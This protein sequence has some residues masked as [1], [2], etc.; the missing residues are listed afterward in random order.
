MFTS[1]PNL[2]WENKKRFTLAEAIKLSRIPSF[3]NWKTD[4][5]KKHRCPNKHKCK[6]NWHAPCIFVGGSGNFAT[7]TSTIHILSNISHNCPKN[8]SNHFGGCN[9]QLWLLTDIFDHPRR[10]LSPRTHRWEAGIPCHCCPRPLRRLA[11]MKY[12]PKTAKNSEQ[13]PSF[14]KRRLAS[15]KRWRAALFRRPSVPESLAP[16]EDRSL[17]VS[18]LH[19]TFEKSWSIYVTL[20]RCKQE[21]QLSQIFPESLKRY[22]ISFFGIVCLI[23]E[24]FSNVIRSTQV[25]PILQLTQSQIIQ[26]ISV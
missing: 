3:S 11:V 20:R 9:S 26:I 5:L 21:F 7:H 10:I 8:A 4:L 17:S 12:I 23:I 15:A 16:S 6:Q 19:K 13:A 22:Q 24:Q 14:P 2:M 18:C 25:I 1:S